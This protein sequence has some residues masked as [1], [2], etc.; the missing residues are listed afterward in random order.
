MP[1]RT[2]AD[3]L[4][5]VFEYFGRTSLTVTGPTTGNLY[6][7]G[8]SGARVR[9]DLRDRAQLLGIPNLRVAR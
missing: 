9:V 4:S 2:P 1:A 8:A 5:V 3:T 6:R 7:F